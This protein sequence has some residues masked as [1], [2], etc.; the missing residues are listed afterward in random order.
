MKIRYVSFEFSFYRKMTKK[1]KSKNLSKVMSL[2]QLLFDWK[3]N[4]FTNRK[5]DLLSIVSK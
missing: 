1:I 2:R 4:R 3:L 5:M